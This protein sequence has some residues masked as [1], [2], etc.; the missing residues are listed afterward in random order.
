[1]SEILT[2]EWR[3]ICL[4]GLCECEL[5]RKLAILERRGRTLLKGNHEFGPLCVDF[6]HGE[7][8]RNGNPVHLRKMELRLLRYLIER[9]GNVASRDELL[10]SVWG[11]GKG[12]FTRTVDMHVHCLRDKLEHDAKRPELIVTV[13]GAGYKFVWYGN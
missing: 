3:E 12:A 1:M 11:Y 8:K 4:Q 2:G 5:D 7:V 9:D 13:R 6:A 10:H